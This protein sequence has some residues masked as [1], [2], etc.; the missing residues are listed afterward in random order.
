MVLAALRMAD[1]GITHTELAQHRG[2]HLTGEGAGGLAGHVLRT[3]GDGAAGQQ[4]CTCARYGRWHADRNVAGGDPC[5]PA[6][7]ALTSASL[8]ARLPFIFQL[9][10]ISFLVSCRTPG[11]NELADVLVGFHQ[12]VRTRG[13][14]GHPRR[15]GR[16]TLLWI[17]GLIRRFDQRPDMFQAVGDRLLER[18]RTRPQRGAG[19]GQAPAQHQPGIELALDAALHRD[20]RQAAVIGQAIDL[21][22]M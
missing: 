9:P 16:R 8:A 7:T 6:S 10:A 20:D 18:N 13:A 3:Q 14:T 2:R 4:P 21:A 17:T 12:R 19:D 5:R 15:Q 11:Q 1:D 22:G